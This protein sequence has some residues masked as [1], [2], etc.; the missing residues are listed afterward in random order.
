MLAGTQNELYFERMARSLKDKVKM[1]PHVKPGKVLDV[2]AGGGE[3]TLALIE[4]GNDAIALDG[5]QEAISHI[6]DKGVPAVCN[7]THE[8]AQVFPSETFDTIVCSS[9]LHEVFSYGDDTADSAFTVHSL[10]N[11]IKQ[12]HEVLV[13]GGRL[14]IRDGIAP[15]N[16]DEQ[17]KI[18]FKD[19][20]GVRM[21]NK[22]LNMIPFRA[23]TLPAGMHEVGFIVDE[24]EQSLI[25]DA[26]SIMEFL[27]TY[28]WGEASYEREAQ[29]LYGVFTLDEYS[30]F[31]ES[32]G[33]HITYAEEYLQEGYPQHLKNKV[34]LYRED[35]SEA[36]FPMSNCLIVAEK[37]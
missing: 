31:L 32:H 28:T 9:I 8:V 18:L 21:A 35:G 15:A 10:E 27:Y 22:Y 25:G 7:F 33:F 6:V 12:F 37:K 13:T 29:E 36:P 1:L 19:P 4:L 34:A 26:H 5:S 11:S 23:D 16:R 20:D 30:A 14:V 2:G 24:I 17:I 3:L